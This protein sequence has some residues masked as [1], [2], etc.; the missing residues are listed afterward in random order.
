M[1]LRGSV[2]SQPAA[3][4]GSDP[5]VEAGLRD[6][7]V[8]QAGLGEEARA[9]LETAFDAFLELDKDGRITDWNARAETLLGWQRNAV[10]GKPLDTML[11]ERHRS[12]FETNFRA[13]VTDGSKAYNQPFRAKALHRDGRELPIEITPVPL[14]VSEEFRLGCFIRDMTE[15]VRLAEALAQAQDHTTLLNSIEDAY[16]ELD[17]KGNIRFVNDAY[18]AMFHRT[19]E[20]VL[21]PSYNYRN[22]YDPDRRE[23]VRELFKQVYATGEPV[24]GAEF[25]FDAGRFCEMTISL[26]RNSKR[27]AVGFQCLTREITHRKQHQLELARAKEAAEGANRAKSEFLA[28]MSHE[29]RTPMNAIIGMT[30]LTLSTELNEEQREFLSL[31]QSSAAALLVIINDILDYSKIEAGKVELS[32]TEF[33]LEE[34][35]GDAM[36]NLGISA[37]KKSLELAF[38]LEP[39]VPIHLLGDSGRL[40]QVLLNLT[41]NAIKFTDQGEV[42][43]NVALQERGTDGVKLHFTVHD[44]GIGI[45][46]EKQSKLFQPFEQADSSTTRQYGGTGLGLAICRRIVEIMGGE[47]W[48]ESTAGAG[49]TFHFTI[50][51]RENTTPSAAREPLPAEDLRGMRVLIVDDNATNRKILQEMTLRW[52]MHPECA[53]SGA[54]GLAKLQEASAGGRPFRTILV[55]ERM[56][57]MDGIE[58]I[59]HI[60]ATPDLSGSTILMLTSDDRSSSA[61]RCR[62]LGVQSY[63]TKPV[64]PSDILTAVLKALGKSRDPGVAASVPAASACP[65]RSLRILLAEDNLTNQKLAQVLLERMGHRIRLASNGA[66]VIA[67][68][69]SGEFDLIVMD[70]QMPQIDGLEATRLIRERERATGAH[71]PIIAATAHA[72]HGDSERCLAAGADDYV[73]KPI[74]RESLEKALAPY[75]GA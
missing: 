16:L 59:R 75:T 41:G 45:P 36:R 66:E 2:P 17:L 12:A 61:V 1:S 27:E 43:V 38:H 72:M 31:V 55:D 40:R 68:W 65:K 62:E 69:S 50:Q 13:V 33:N 48:L 44:T 23:F 11:P 4:K 35:L 52:G 71:I 34:L 9:I 39:D 57:S 67:D 47:I 15:Q 7:S 24:R 53:D 8:A 73:A 21:D 70:V 18:C 64:S 25:E 54:A 56:P 58:V 10:L 5:E 26:K 46:P 37:H 49:S 29:I 22:F 51:A 63:V 20:E 19:R 30:D 32:P 6:L 14:R 74:S 28:N 60:R 3:W 42:V